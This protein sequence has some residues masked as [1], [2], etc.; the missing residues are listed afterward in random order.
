MNTNTISMALAAAGLMVLATGCSVTEG[1][2]VAD[3][4]RSSTQNMLR[5]QLA[6]PDAALNAS[7]AAPDGLDGQKAG[8]ALGA[9]RGDNAARDFGDVNVDSGSVTSG[10]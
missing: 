7:G 2:R 1:R 4:Y 6:D 5:G 8:R 3:D 10:N 9:Y